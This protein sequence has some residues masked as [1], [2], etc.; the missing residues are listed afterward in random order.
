MLV[1]Q[2]Q[3]GVQRPLGARVGRG[4]GGVDGGGGRVLCRGGLLGR[5]SARRR[6]AVPRRREDDARVGGRRGR[7]L[8]VLSARLPGLGE[9][10]VAAL[11]QRWWGRWWLVAGQPLGGGLDIV[12]PKD[13]TGVEGVRAH[14][15]CQRG[16]PSGQWARLQLEFC[17][18]L[19]ALGHAALNNAT[20]E[21]KTSPG[22]SAADKHR[23]LGGCL[24]GWHH[25]LWELKFL[26]SS[27]AC[28]R[29]QYLIRGRT[30]GWKNK[31]GLSSAFVFR[32][33]SWLLETGGE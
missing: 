6:A 22:I 17:P 29:G 3:M 2:G 12:L 16:D 31:T 26:A 19:S 28:H 33:L 1:D 20:P 32:G 5:G 21:W 4:D 25:C 15:G 30:Q 8:E 14:R 11:G 24:W 13:P 7:R 10:V 27:R 23:D 18:P 9:R